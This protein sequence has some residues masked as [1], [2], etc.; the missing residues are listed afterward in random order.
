MDCGTVVGVISQYD[1]GVVAADALSKVAKV[2]Q[3]LAQITQE[4]SYIHSMVD[5]IYTQTE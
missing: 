3:G 5:S 2:P 1:P 4:L